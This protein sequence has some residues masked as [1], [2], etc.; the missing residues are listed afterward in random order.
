MTLEILGEQEYQ[1]YLDTLE[2]YSTFQTTQMAALLQKRGNETTYL[3][4]RV[5]GELVVQG[6][7]LPNL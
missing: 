2:S 3:G 1:D 6:L 4:L 7:S 5:E